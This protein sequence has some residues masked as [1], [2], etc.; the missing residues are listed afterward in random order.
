ME[1]IGI[2]FNHWFSSIYG[3]IEDI[4]KRMGNRVNIV[5][6]SK[7]RNHACRNVAD[8][9]LVEPDEMGDDLYIER[10]LNICKQYEI[11]IFFPRDKAQL[12]ARNKYRFEQLGVNVVIE[13]ADILNIIDNKVCTYEKLK[14][15]YLDTFIPYYFSG[16]EDEKRMIL[17]RIDRDRN[18]CVKMASDEG[19]KSF[20][21]IENGN[22]VTFNSLNDYRVNRISNAEAKSIVETAGAKLN[23]LI[24]MEV[25]DTPEISVDCYASRKGFISICRRKEHGRVEKVYTDEALSKI[26]YMISVIFKL[27]KPFNVQ[28]RPIKGGDIHNI[29]DLRLLEINTR[30]S[31]GVYFETAIGL[32][33][34]QVYIEDTIGSKGY[35]Y[36]KYLNFENY[37]T[38]VEKAEVLGNE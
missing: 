12:I 36:E 37:V 19:G 25:L 34:A 7:N 17:S 35:E 6:E 27:E 24:F 16:G 20:R 22:T 38:Y 10:C 4:K 13:D 33:L 8:V 3:V 1:T 29:Q 9:F 31:G 21:I 15:S 26:C 32:N 11:K 2:Y 18:L 28:F 30:L 23:K 5:V 14:N